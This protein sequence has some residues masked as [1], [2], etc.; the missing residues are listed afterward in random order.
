MVKVGLVEVVVVDLDRD[1]E[2][3][4]VTSLTLHIVLIKDLNHAVVA[5]A[6]LALAAGPT[7]NHTHH[8]IL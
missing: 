8:T 4:D 3:D 6:R 1:L 7:D 2:A 5:P